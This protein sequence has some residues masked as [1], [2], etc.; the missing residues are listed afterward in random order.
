MKLVEYIES[1]NQ[2]AMMYI[3]SQNPQLRD[4]HFN[5]NRLSYGDKTLDLGNFS[6]MSLMG[7]YTSFS[8]DLSLMEPRDFLDIVAVHI[9]GIQQLAT[10]G[11]ERNLRDCFYQVLD[12]APTNY[13]PENIVNGYNAFIYDMMCY[14]DYLTPD[15][16]PLLQEFQDE[17]E[18]VAINEAPSRIQENELQT[19]YGMREQALGFQEKFKKEKEAKFKLTLPK[20][21]AGYV[22]AF[23]IAIGISFIGVIIASLVFI[24]FG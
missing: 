14:Q 3:V 22:N 16:S 19:Y 13:R 15:V 12:G 23:I 9:L 10:Q 8:Q 1:L 5:N 17:M 24:Y 18:L 2:R 4:V 20:E 7:D 11:Q 6:L 21:K